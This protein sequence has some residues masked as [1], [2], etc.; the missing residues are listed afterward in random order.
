MSADTLILLATA[1]G[2]AAAVMAA[3]WAIQKRTRNAAIVDAAWTGLVGGLAVFYATQAHA[4]WPWR[5]MAIASMIGSWGAR[6]T[7]H[8]LYDRVFGKPED[9]R[10]RDLRLRMEARADRVFFW[11]FQLQ[12]ISAVLFAIPALLVAVNPADDFSTSE[13]VGAALWA[14]AFSGETTAD[15]QLWHF[16]MNPANQGRTCRDGL[17]RYSRHPNYFF[18]WLIWVAVALFATSSP[19]GWVSWVCPTLMLY[20]LVRV[21]GIPP[22]EAQ[23]L[24]TRGDDYR[25][26][27]RTT[28]PFVPL[29]STSRQP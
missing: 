27:Q 26:Y 14:A 28:S 17:W 24:R 16:K 23:A 29:P 4:G 11:I 25:E 15:R 7:V 5:R 21:T 1:V 2:I 20:L 12:A 10:Y 18:E 3:C 13:L 19:V 6:L 22:T 9:G 8:L